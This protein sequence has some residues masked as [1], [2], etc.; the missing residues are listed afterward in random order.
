LRRFFR[1]VGWGRLWFFSSS[2]AVQALDCRSIGW[3][4]VRHRDDQIGF[5]LTSQVWGI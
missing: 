2:G 4:K 3:L 5:I 1:L